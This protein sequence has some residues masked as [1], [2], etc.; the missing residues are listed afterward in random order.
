[1]EKEELKEFAKTICKKEQ[2]YFILDGRF[3]AMIESQL[4]I[5][6]MSKKVS[7]NGKAMFV[8]EGQYDKTRMMLPAMDLDDKKHIISTIHLD[9]V[10]LMEEISKH[11][12][13]ANSVLIPSPP[14]ALLSDGSVEGSD[15]TIHADYDLNEENAE[16]SAESIIGFVACQ[17][18]TRLLVVI[19]NVQMEV[20]FNTGSI[21][22]AFGTLLHAGV[23]YTCPNLRLHWYGDIKGNNRKPGEVYFSLIVIYTYIH[24][25]IY[26]FI[27]VYVHLSIYLYIYLSIYPYIHIYLY[28]SIYLSI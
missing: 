20:T 8:R 22:V 23:G 18:N 11:N 1:M 4:D 9:M 2:E 14:Y 5:K 3:K 21:F 27:F 16:K 6:A 26:I 13:N 12:H 25:C 10:Y 15:Q 7:D 17:D 24:V 28:L 19:N